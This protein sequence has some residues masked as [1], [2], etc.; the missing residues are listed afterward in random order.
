MK[1]PKTS[2]VVCDDYVSGPFTPERAARQLANQKHLD[3][4]PWEHEIVTSETK[5]EVRYPVPWPDY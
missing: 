2:W 1:A 4:C 3:Y 5:P